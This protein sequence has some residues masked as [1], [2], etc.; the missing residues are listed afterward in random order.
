MISFNLSAPT[1]RTFA[2]TVTHTVYASDVDRVYNIVNSSYGVYIVDPDTWTVNG[3]NLGA[4]AASNSVNVYDYV[5]YRTGAQYGN[6]YGAIYILRF[7]N[8]ST[9]TFRVGEIT[10]ADGESITWS[11][12]PL[13]PE[14]STANSGAVYDPLSDKLY[15]MK[16]SSAELYE[17]DFSSWTSLHTHSESLSFPRLAFS[18]NRGKVYV[19]SGTSFTTPLALFSYDLTADTF[20]QMA[21]EGINTDSLD[22][23]KSLVVHRDHLVMVQ[24]SNESA[25][26][27]TGIWTYDLSTDGPWAITRYDLGGHEDYAPYSPFYNFYQGPFGNQDLLNF[28][29]SS[30]NLLLLGDPTRHLDTSSTMGVFHSINRGATLDSGKRFKMRATLRAKYDYTRGATLSAKAQTERSG[31]LEGV[32]RYSRGRSTTL[33]CGEERTYDRP[34]TLSGNTNMERSATLKTNT[35]LTRLA[36][37]RTSPQVETSFTLEKSKTRVIKIEN[38]ETDGSSQMFFNQVTIKFDKPQSD[39]FA[40]SVTL[41]SMF[42]KSYYGQTVSRTFEMPLVFDQVT[43]INIAKNLLMQHHVVP[44]K[45]E[46]AYSEPLR[47]VFTGNFVLLNSANGISETGDFQNLTCRVKTINRD[48]YSTQEDRMTLVSNDYYYLAPAIETVEVATTGVKVTL[49]SNRLTSQRTFTIV[50][51]AEGSKP[52]VGAK[53]T[54]VQTGDEGVTDNFGN[55]SFFLTTGTYLIRVESAGHETRTFTESVV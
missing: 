33:I 52:I 43:A 45:I 7:T 31:I 49:T 28:R 24:F 15:Y 50:E 26:E 39:D 29:E 41:E 22:L 12:G 40:Q 2:T 23:D 18:S 1:G 16:S 9:M 25:D 5:F 10:S 48:Q 42:S 21:N 53:V 34:A 8:A 46:V 3:T 51:D 13:Y 6:T 4:Y 44:I 55:V 35:K 19:Y 20:T 30:N 11:D 54:I 47:E 17:Y 14:T 27:S 36:T 37:F 38:Y 32:A